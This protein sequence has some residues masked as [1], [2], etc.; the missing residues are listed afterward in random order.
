MQ[1]ILK[2]VTHPELGE[3][4][5]KDELFAIGRHEAP[6]S[7]YETSFIE[8][9]SRRH[10][11]IFEQDDAVYIAD[12]GS[13]NGTTVNGASL[14]SLPV[15]LQR[16][17]EICF[18]GH[19]CYQIEILG[20][21]ASQSSE[22]AIPSA[23]QL[24]LT[25]VE[26]ASILEPIVVTQFPFLVNKS[27]D[28][29]S[30]YRNSLPEESGFISRRH[31][32]IFL[33]DGD[34]YVEDLGSTNGTFIG[35][36]RLEEHAR[37]LEEGDV[38]A[39][40]G[41]T[42]AYRVGLIRASDASD[43]AT[44]TVDEHSELLTGTA[45]AIEDPTRTT[46][47]TSA[48]SFLDIFCAEDEN[49]EDD[50]LDSKVVAGSVKVQ[51]EGVPA[52]G[53]LHKYRSIFAEVRHAFSDS[54]DKKS[55]KVWLALVAILAAVAVGIYYMTSSDQEVRDLLEQGAYAEAATRANHY[56]ELN[57]GNEE[58]S[59]LATE[60]VLKEIVP[61]W[62]D[63]LAAGDFNQA[64]KQIERGKRLGSA[65]PHSQQL[66]DAMSWVTRLERF[67]ATR[68]GPDEPV[69]MYKE[70][71]S[72]SDLVAWWKEDSKNRRRSLSTIAQHVA[73]FTALR[74]QVFSHLRSLQNQKSLSLEAIEHLQQRVHQQ[75][76][77][78]DAQSLYAILDEFERKYPRITGV[79]TMRN[80]LDKYLL[81]ESELQSNHWIQA[82]QTAADSTFATPLFQQ[83]VA[84]IVREQLP[85]ESVTRRYR[86][87]R[88]DWQ[89]GNT[90]KAIDA[91]ELLKNERWG[92]VADRSL[93]HK[94]KLIDDFEQLQESSGKPGYDKQIL[95]F[96]RSLDPLEDVW[97]VASVEDEFQRYRS[98][99]LDKAKQQFAKARVAWDRYKKDGGIRGLQ[100][101]QASVTPVFRR[102]ATAL[103]DAYDAIAEAMEI[104][105]LLDIDT[106]SEWYELYAR[107]TKEVRLQRQSLTELEMVLE[108]SLRRAKLELL[109][110][111]NSQSAGEE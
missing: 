45:H 22:E 18:T 86:Q 10:A 110:V 48:N 96:Y 38:I 12:L 72:I 68:G 63:A 24:I 100:R 47:V 66:F 80:D 14:D 15:K 3:I 37:K 83:R 57:P 73:D 103:S 28:V 39:F 29:F 91:L 33:R 78:G 70:E 32:H 20:A 58:I 107:I 30:R 55:G 23:V 1:V 90:D 64:E 93:Q 6:F 59:E 26:Q 79:Q 36:E 2:P 46:F 71:D 42:F 104:H 77:Q 67:I 40:G 27:S 111:L 35:G 54:K 56:L 76:Q 53:F 88:M 50:S 13:L 21:A 109:P 102:L 105:K 25:P 41:E 31:A 19:L 95:A 87:A 61:A 89:Q 43:A 69:I 8:K 44:T 16:G 65:N 92:E 85:P 34:V 62:I 99:A 49:R 5:I 108:P 74:P 11:R 17:D 106:Q 98:K 94:R 81:V 4:I 84:L 82:Q 97:F 51:K 9:L 60:A 7:A 75:L 101:L 52:T